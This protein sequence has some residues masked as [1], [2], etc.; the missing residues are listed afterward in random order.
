MKYQNIQQKSAS[1]LA[2]QQQL[3][4]LQQDICLPAVILKHSA[5]QHNLHWMQNFADSSEVLLAPHGKTSMTLSAEF[6]KQDPIFNYERPYSDPTYGT[7][8]FAGSVNI[9]GSFY[10]LDPTKNAPATT[11][12]GLPAAT[13]VTNGTYSGPRAQGD[14]LFLGRAHGCWSLLLQGSADS[15]TPPPRQ[16][17][18]S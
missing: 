9:G 15:I 8:T 3:N 16:T 2:G 5:L 4:L 1:P 12:G 13:L 10:Y 14:Q 6:V 7:P 18:P 17:S 11:A